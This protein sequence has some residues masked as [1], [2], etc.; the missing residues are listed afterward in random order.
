MWLFWLLWFAPAFAGEP[1]PDLSQA[2]TLADELGLGLNLEIKAPRG[3]GGETMGAVLEALTRHGADP[4]RIVLSSFD[5]A[6]LRR[7]RGQFALAIH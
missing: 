7:Q 6:A 4:G 5:R 2:L 1:V 3:C